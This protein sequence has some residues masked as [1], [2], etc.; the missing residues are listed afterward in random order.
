ML[1]AKTSDSAT[2]AAPKLLDQV[3]G[4]IHLKHY[5]IRTERAYTDWIRR[6]FCSTGS[7]IRHGTDGLRGAG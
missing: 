6:S 1:P 2:L 3:R 4:N 5:S 7:A